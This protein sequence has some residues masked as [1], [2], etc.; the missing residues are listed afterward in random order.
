[1]PSEQTG[2]LQPLSIRE[3]GLASSA[4]AT[5]LRFHR[6]LLVFVKGGH[7][8]WEALLGFGEALAESFILCATLRLPQNPDGHWSYRYTCS[9]PSQPTM[10]LSVFLSAFVLLKTCGQAGS[11]C[12]IS[13]R[14]SRGLVPSVL[15]PLGGVSPAL[16]KCR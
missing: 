2:D 8:N 6:M 7:R 4:G 14:P 12:A 3:Q 16:P 10:T 15:F 1:M 5:E 11:G 9:F 13:G